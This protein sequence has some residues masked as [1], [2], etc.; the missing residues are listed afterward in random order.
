[1]GDHKEIWEDWCNGYLLELL[2]QGLNHV[3]K[4]PKDFGDMNESEFNLWLSKVDFNRK[5]DFG[6]LYKINP[7]SK[8]ECC[9]NFQSM[10]TDL[11]NLPLS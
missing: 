6:I 8:R 5:D 1:M 9:R 3:P 4:P 10:K 2:D 7:P 11:V